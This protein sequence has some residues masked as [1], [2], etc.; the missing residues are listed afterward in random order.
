MPNF[1]LREAPEYG[2]APNLKRAVLRLWWGCSSSD[3]PQHLAHKAGMY[4]LMAFG[5]LVGAPISKAARI[6]RLAGHLA[7][8][9]H[10]AV[11]LAECTS[12]AHLQ[13]EYLLLQYCSSNSLHHILLADLPTAASRCTPHHGAIPEGSR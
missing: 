11:H 6:T 3:Y 4:L 2:Q 9:I 7:G 8:M 13:C 12:T 10:R 5:H 1:I